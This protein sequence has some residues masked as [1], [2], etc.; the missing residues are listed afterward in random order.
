[1]NN[2]LPTFDELP[3]VGA[4]IKIIGKHPWSG[5]TAEVIGH[6]LVGIV[7]RRQRA[8]CRLIRADAMDG[9]EFY[10]EN[11]WRLAR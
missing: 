10:V 1:M 11:E 3:P 5:E 6:H 2:R 4:I 8:K 9:H 7:S